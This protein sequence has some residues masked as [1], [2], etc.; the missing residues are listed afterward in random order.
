MLQSLNSDFEQ[1][2]LLWI[3]PVGFARRDA[4]KIRVEGI[5]VIQERAPL[6]GL[7]YRVRGLRRTVFER[8]PPTLGHG[9]YRR[10]TGSKEIPQFV[11]T[12]NIS[13]QPTAQADHRDRLVRR[14]T[15]E[16]LGSARHLRVGVQQRFS[17]R[18]DRRVLPK[19]HR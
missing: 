1:K 6:R 14:T 11:R 10:A 7:R 9:R 3:D 8:L 2:T 5:D 4:E 16:A 17:Q 13:R 15:G 18:V 19:V 12:V